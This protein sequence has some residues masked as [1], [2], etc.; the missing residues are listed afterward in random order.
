MIINLLPIIFYIILFYMQYKNAIPDIYIGFIIPVLL[1]FVS[2]V[3]FSLFNVV[4]SDTAE[5]FALQNTVYG[6]SQII[7]QFLNFVLYYDNISNDS[8]TEMLS[9]MGLFSTVI[10]VLILTLVFY[11]IKRSYI[12]HRENRK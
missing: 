11:A 4:F 9:E 8:E 3:I 10:Y 7:G 5:R 1:F 6:F 12:K 2:P